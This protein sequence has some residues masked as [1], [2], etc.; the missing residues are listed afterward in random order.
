MQETK[1]LF[2]SETI[3]LVM[4]PTDGSAHSIRA[5]EYALSIAKVHNAKI[6]AVFVIDNFVIDQFSR[7]PARTNIEKDLTDSGQSY[8]NYIVNMAEKQ[9]VA[10]ESIITKGQPFEQI[11]NLAKT[12]NADLIVMGTTGRR[13]TER[14]LIGSVTQRVIE[15]SSCPVLVIK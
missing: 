10:V 4:V 9:G 5:A 15:Y 3:K 14:I 6:L 12:H 7:V 13:S 1:K 2:S 11:L 8:L